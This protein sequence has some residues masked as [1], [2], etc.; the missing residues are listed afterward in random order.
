MTLLPESSR[1]AVYVSFAPVEK[2]H[3]DHGAFRLRQCIG[4]GNLLC[5][6]GD[7]F[8][9]ATYQKLPIL[10][11]TWPQVSRE[12]LRSGRI[13][14]QLFENDG[15][16]LGGWAR[17]D[18]VRRWK[19]GDENAL[20][21]VGP[22][23]PYN[24]DWTHGR[25]LAQDQSTLKRALYAIAAPSVWQRVE[26]QRPSEPFVAVHVRRGDFNNPVHHV[27]DGGGQRINQPI[28]IEWYV[29]AIRDARRTTGHTQAV[30]FSD[31]TD[32]ELSSLTRLGN[33]TVQRDNAMVDLLTAS[34]A[35]AFVASGSTFS[36]WI[37]YLGQMPTWLNP[38]F[39]WS[40]NLHL[41]PSA[42]IALS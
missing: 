30:V 5:S 20:V 24:V 11:P 17:R 28:P 9:Y 33:V 38:S 25:D 18:C 4:L 37:S 6:W 31:G 36:Q 16:Y 42:R 7:A 2:M 41:D 22:K 23:I 29:E 3:Q 19:A 27:T 15:T 32:A 39:A 21:I 8:L 35:T 10:W 40:H 12:A 1:C 34:C 14:A 13:Y 26:R